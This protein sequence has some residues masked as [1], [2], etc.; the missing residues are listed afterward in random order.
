MP[1]TEKTQP[2]SPGPRLRALRR[3]IDYALAESED[4]GKPLLATFLGA[5]AL[6]VDE[7]SSAPNRM[8]AAR[9]APNA[10]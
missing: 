8:P 3:L 5:A 9:T 1:E 4:L 2:S 10:N 7:D 6:V